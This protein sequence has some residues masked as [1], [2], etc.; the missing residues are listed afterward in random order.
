MDN[1]VP[2]TMRAVLQPAYGG[3]EVWR[4]G[5]VAVPTPGPGRV[6][7][8]VEA[9]GVDQGTWHLLTGRPYPCPG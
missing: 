9:A 4:L 7:V 1:Q 5:A 6:L 2:T 8:Q 3:A